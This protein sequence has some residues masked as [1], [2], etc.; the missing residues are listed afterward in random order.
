[1]L[2]NISKQNAISN[3]LGS[4]QAYP[5]LEHEELVALFQTY[6]QGGVEATK[7]RKKLTESNLRLVVYIAKK[8]KG[9]N[10]PLEDLIQEGNLGLLKAI[11]KFDW[12]KGFRFS[13][14]ATWWIK[15]AI[16][17]YVLKRKKIIR[18]PAHAASAQ[19]KLI[20]A[21]D[22]FKELKGYGP[23]SEEL[24]EMIDVSETVVKATMA[25]GKNIVSLQQQIGTDGSSTLEDKIEDTNFANDPFES[26]A[27]KEMMTIV[28]KVMSGLSAKEAA[29]LRL[30]F[31]LYEDIEPKEF[32]VT[33]E[34]ARL[35]AK[36]QGLT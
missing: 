15:Q 12:K 9:H 11:D 36:G 2:N 22:A 24:S 16:S 33:K 21:S 27:K 18:L 7:A 5:Q 3:Y 23:T 35:I 34:Q 1:M 29:I 14:Y 20:E 6:E 25:S 28:K 10:I 13:T 31:G 4:L 19:K 8:Q 30:R 26:L 32:E 17:Q